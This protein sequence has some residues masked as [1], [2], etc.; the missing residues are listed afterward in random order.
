MKDLFCHIYLTNHDT[1]MQMKKH[2]KMIAY[3]FQSILKIL[4]D[5]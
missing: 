5:N 3:V 1:V 2:W 4:H